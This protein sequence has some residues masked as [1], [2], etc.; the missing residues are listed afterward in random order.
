MQELTHSKKDGFR[1]Q[2]KSLFLYYHRKAF[3]RLKEEELILDV[4]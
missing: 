4:I 3:Y 1:L 2:G